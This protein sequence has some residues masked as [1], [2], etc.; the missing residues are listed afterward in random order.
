MNDAHMLRPAS[1]TAR[2]SAAVEA[3]LLFQHDLRRLRAHVRHPQP[4][5]WVG[6]LLP[7]ALVLG[8]FWI[9]GERAQPGLDSIESAAI[10]GFVI[11]A[12]LAFFSYGVL[13]RPEDDPFLRRLGFSALAF[14]MTR[15]LRL[16]GAGLSV[17]AVMLLPFVST[18]AAV[19]RPVAIGVT[20][21]VVAWALTLLGF[22]LAAES[23]VPT[24]GAR[25]QGVFSRAMAYDREL[26][27]VAPLFYAPLAPLL[28]AP[29]AAGVVAAAPGAPWI[30][31][32]FSLAVAFVLAL[33]AARPF[34]RA[35]PRFAALA[36]EMTFAPP[37][38]AGEVGLVLDR[39][40]AR[41]LPRKVA[42]VRARDAAVSGRRFRWATSIVWPVALVSAVALARWG[43]EA[44]VRSWVLIAGG[45][46]LLAQGGAT[47]ALGRI[48]RRG[49]GWIDRGAGIGWGVRWA[50][51][52]AFGVGLA[53]WLVV[54]LALVWSWWAPTSPGWPWL[55]AGAAVAALAALASVAAAGR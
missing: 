8:A 15:A 11:A 32:V 41:L 54:P 35:L 6:V 18:G 4:G 55:V 49:A 5:V 53:L 39:G 31:V 48:E 10:W 37:P 24:D 30:R 1:P 34:V 26:A 13:F 19:A 2:R 44:G 33:A 3:M 7:A 42:A 29:V 12:P 9:A 51:R 46:A 38:T 45:A 14:M 25:R 27:G 20:A 47:V 21:A 43:D 22:S 28:G 23:T 50:G 17:L 40:L 52:W 16:L 36:Q